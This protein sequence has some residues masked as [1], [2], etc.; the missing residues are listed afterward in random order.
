MY[1]P[2]QAITFL[3]HPSS[4]ASTTQ[5]SSSRSAKYKHQIMILLILAQKVF[6]DIVALLFLENLS[7]SARTM[8][9]TGSKATSNRSANY[10]PFT[11]IHSQ[12]PVSFILK[13]SK[14]FPL[15]RCQLPFY[16]TQ[17]SHLFFSF[18]TMFK[19]RLLDSFFL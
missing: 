18:F 11:I 17:I 9:Q 5:L 13:A 1:V 7:A 12:R 10:V 6:V 16:L 14:L 8:I 15:Q 19:V 3:L 4:K 2:S